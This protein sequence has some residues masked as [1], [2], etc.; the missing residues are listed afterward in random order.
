MMNLGVVVAQKAMK[1]MVEGD[2]SEFLLVDVGRAEPSQRAG[3]QIGV[4]KELLFR[5]Q[6]TQY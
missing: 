5:Y 6:Q 4:Q 1:A 3:L 2:T